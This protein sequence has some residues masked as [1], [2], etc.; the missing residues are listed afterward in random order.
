MGAP[1]VV[2]AEPPPLLRIAVPFFRSASSGRDPIFFGTGPEGRWNDAQEAYGVLYAAESFEGSVVETVLHSRDVRVVFTSQVQRVAHLLLPQRVLR[3]IDLGDG[4]VLRAL[5]TDETVTKGDFRVCQALSR[6][7]FEAPWRPDGIRYV[8]RVDPQ[9]ACVALF[10]PADYA[11]VSFDLG[12]VRL[13]PCRTLFAHVLDRLGVTL[14][15][16]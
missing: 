9:Q 12:H 14:V 15:A 6:A 2:P 10:G 7:I 16:D 8:S 5:S 3:L 1:F 4:A 13:G 11:V